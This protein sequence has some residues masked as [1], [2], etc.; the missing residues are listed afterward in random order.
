VELPAGV[1]EGTAVDV[2]VE[3]HLVVDTADGRRTVG[4]GDVVH[5]RPR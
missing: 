2:T 5:L 4:V 3:G 1:L